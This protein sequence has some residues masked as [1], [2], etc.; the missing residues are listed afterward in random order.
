MTRMNRTNRTITDPLQAIRDKLYPYRPP[1]MA[2]VDDVLSAEECRR[3]IQRMEETG[4]DVAT[5]N[6]GGGRMVLN[7][8]VR[9]NDRVIFDDVPLAMELFTRLRPAIPDTAAGVNGRNVPGDGDELG[10]AIGLNERF[11]AYRYSPGQ[12]FAPH[13]DG[14]FRRDEDEVSAIT[15]IIYLNGGD[16]FEGGDTAFLDFEL[17][18]KPKRGMALL[19]AHPILH[20]GCLVTSGRKYALRTDV[21]YRWPTR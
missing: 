12:R 5:I 1:F 15:V 13:F 4:P 14:A 18:V 8:N 9:N 2:L 16:E 21:M 6:A 10:R 17:V 3:E 7:T 20:E 19:F 11:R